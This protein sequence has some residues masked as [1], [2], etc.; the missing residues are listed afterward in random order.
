MVVLAT[1]PSSLLEVYDSQEAG[2]DSGFDAHDY[3]RQQHA[4]QVLAHMASGYAEAMNR[5]PAGTRIAPPKLKGNPTGQAGGPPGKPGN[6]LNV[7]VSKV[8]DYDNGRYRTGP[9]FNAISVSYLEDTP[10]ADIRKVF[11]TLTDNTY[12]KATGY[13]VWEMEE[14]TVLWTTSKTVVNPEW[15]DDTKTLGHLWRHAT[16]STHGTLYVS[17]I[18]MS[19]KVLD[20]HLVVNPDPDRVIVEEDADTPVKENPTNRSKR[21]NSVAASD[22]QTSNGKKPRA[23]T[24]KDA[25]RTIVHRSPGTVLNVEKGSYISNGV[26]GYIW[27]VDPTRLKAIIEDKCFASGETKEVY[28]MLIADKSYAAKRF[29]YIGELGST[30]SQEDNLS[31]LKDELLR[32]RLVSRTVD[33]FMAAARTDKI[34]VYNLRMD[35]SFIVSVTDGPHKGDAFL[36][37][38]LISETAEV[39]KFSGTE[40]A[41]ANREDLVGR[42]ADAFAHYSYFDSD[43]TIVLVDIQGIDSE[44]LRTGSRK[45]QTTAH[46]LT[47]FDIMIHSSTMQYGLGDDG[48]SGIQDFVEQ[49]EC[50]GICRALG[51]TDV[52]IIYDASWPDTTKSKGKAKQGAKDKSDHEEEGTSSSNAGKGLGGLA[53]Y[54][55][56]EE[57]D[58]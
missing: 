22:L 39:R 52:D 5:G 8:T 56:G 12:M 21:A 37:D 55:G 44:T 19:R 35:E 25:Y 2:T 17:K 41:G 34:A 40:E 6:R 57:S 51:L 30:V 27:V 26:G 7:K 42:T 33:K 28:K 13:R 29:F 3:A 11:L 38:P 53:I 24:G 23:A 14:I 15:I 49:H 10:M 54:K 48:W 4:E 1:S 16:D 9:L 50:N 47:L 36:V 31:H 46:G 45:S 20:F 32:N 43:G 58:E 18:D